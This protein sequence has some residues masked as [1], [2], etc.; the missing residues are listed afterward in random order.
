MFKKWKPIIRWRQKHFQ[1]FHSKAVF[2]S[3][4][5]RRGFGRRGHPNRSAGGCHAVSFPPP[6]SQDWQRGDGN[7]PKPFVSPK[8]F[9]PPGAWGSAGQGAAAGLGAHPGRRLPLGPRAAWHGV[10]SRCV[11][12]QR[13]GR[14]HITHGAAAAAGELRY[15]IMSTVCLPLALAT[16]QD[17]AV[18][19]RCG[20]IRVSFLPPGLKEKNTQLQSSL[21]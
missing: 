7:P 21:M 19:L 9:V 15:K 4:E 10:E 17:R 5:Q 14:Q 16:L 12:G 20:L 3:W 11:E 2:P 1:C 18:S 13:S 6:V 8:P